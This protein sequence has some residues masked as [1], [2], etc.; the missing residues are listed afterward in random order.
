MM[1][2]VFRALATATLVIP[3]AL[4]AQSKPGGP[5]LKALDPT[6]TVA[7]APKVRSLKAE[8]SSITLHVGETVGFDKITVVVIDSAGKTRGR[9]IGY[10]FGIKPGEPATAVPRQMTGVR[11]GT[12]ELKILYPISSWKPRK[13]LRA[14]T[15]VKVVVVK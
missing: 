11:P 15:S 3:G 6:E 5:V 10:D 8:P 7:I 12:T 13:D 4:A 1:R 2:F 14:E 9:L